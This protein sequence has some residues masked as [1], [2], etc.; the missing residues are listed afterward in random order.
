M[1]LYWKACIKVSAI[2]LWIYLAYHPNE[3]GK[4]VREEDS[5]PTT[6]NVFT[7]VGAIGD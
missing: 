5:S 3:G 7:K 1:D 4:V 6:S 2:Y